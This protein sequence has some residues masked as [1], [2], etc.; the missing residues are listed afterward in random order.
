MAVY[1]PMENTPILPIS[2]RLIK[3][4]TKNITVFKIFDTWR[5]IDL[6]SACLFFSDTFFGQDLRAKMKRVHRILF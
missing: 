3:Y 6:K 5:T 2:P 4:S 1:S